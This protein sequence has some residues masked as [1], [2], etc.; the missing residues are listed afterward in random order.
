MDLSQKI[1]RATDRLLAVTLVMLVLGSAMAFGGAVWWYPP[2]VVGLTF[3]MVAIRLVQFLL[4]GRMPL[5]KSPLTFLGLLVLTLGTVQLLPMPAGLARR[6]SP[7]AHEVYSSGTWSRLVLADDPEA[8]LPSPASVRSPATL[9]RAATLRWLVGAAVCLGVFWTVSHYVNR[10]NRL[11]WVWGSVAAG[12]LLNAALGIVQIG[13]HAEG[14]Y[15]FVLPGRGAAWA[16]TLDDLLESP[17]PP[18]CVAWRVTRER[19][20]PPST[21]S[22]WL[23]IARS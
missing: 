9:D 5:L 11:Y 19:I 23:P 10:L 22:R 13:G 14:L 7:V 20:G 2:V 6:V 17:A 1:M 18:P 16:P 8:L 3:L 12:F 4:Q 15:G 21:R